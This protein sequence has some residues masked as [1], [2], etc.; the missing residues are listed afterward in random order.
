[1]PGCCSPVYPPTPSVAT[2]SDYRLTPVPERHAQ[3]TDLERYI[4]ERFDAEHGARLTHFQ[5]TLLALIGSEGQ[6]LGAAGYR[7]A[8]AGPLFLE[9]Y[10]DLPIEAAIR[11][12][13]GLALPRSAIVEV[14]NLSASTPGGARLLIRAVTDQLYTLGYTWVCF[15]ATRP[16]HNAFRRLGLAPLVLAD[17]D[18][19]RLGG[20]AALWG[21]YYDSAPQVVAGP[22]A[23]GYR[24]LHGGTAS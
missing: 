2:A 4:A 18:P 16:L 10:L 6:L 14:G 20:E 3:R 17:A 13:T 1:M 11:E 21:R 7:D 5:P 23:L 8:G 9:Q 12:R 22:I 24:K 15:T 19:A